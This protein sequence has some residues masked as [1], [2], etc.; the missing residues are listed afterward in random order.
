MSRDLSVK[1]VVRKET[2]TKGRMGLVTIVATLFLIQIG[3]YLP[4][5]SS[6]IQ[7]RL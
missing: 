4:H 7:I 6:H 2:R 5:T 3:S 1:K